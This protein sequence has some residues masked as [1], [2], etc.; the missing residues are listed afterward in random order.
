M[1]AMA[2]QSPALAPLTTAI[3]RTHD[4]TSTAAETK[5]PRKDSLIE[6]LAVPHQ[7]DGRQE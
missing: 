7:G 2:K 6:Y 5:D 4:D 3:H 1:P